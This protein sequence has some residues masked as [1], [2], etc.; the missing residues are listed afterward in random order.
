[1]IHCG[2]LFWPLK[3]NNKCP[4]IFAEAFANQIPVTGKVTAEDYE[5][6]IMPAIEELRQEHDQIRFLY[7]FDPSFDGFT[8]GAVWDDT[9]VGLMNFTHFKRVAIVTQSALV[10]DGV[11]V[12]GFLV[13][14]QR[15]GYT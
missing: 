9:K 13:P 11:K 7:H 2:P 8:F 6:V 1:M 14:V 15:P 5:T 12:F 3:T 10:A 4:V